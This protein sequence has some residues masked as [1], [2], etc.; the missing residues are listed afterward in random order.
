MSAKILFESRHERKAF[1]IFKNGFV[2]LDFMQQV[3]ACS[4][5]LN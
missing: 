1:S 2:Q 3:V 4:D 5:L